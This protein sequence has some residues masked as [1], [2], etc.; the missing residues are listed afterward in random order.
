VIRGAVL[1]R[2][3][4]DANRERHDVDEHDREEIQHQREEQP[5]ADHVRHRLVVLERVA[6]VAVQQAG[7]P[8]EV[9]LPERLIETVLLAQEGDLLVRH[10]LSHGLD[11]GHVGG[12]IVT[13][14]QLDDDENE[15]A[16][17][18]Q[19]PHHRY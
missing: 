9:L 8:D 3:G 17:A 15:D 4:I 7:D 11:L 18:D 2:G 1:V 16:D 5:V 19:R 13:G 14:R 10:L 12:E 6:Q